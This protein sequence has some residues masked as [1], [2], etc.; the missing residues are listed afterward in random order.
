MTKYANANSVYSQK[1]TPIGKTL[2]FHQSSEEWLDVSSRID[3]FH[4]YKVNEIIEK[5]KNKKGRKPAWLKM[6]K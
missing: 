6:F 5:A 1:M 3:G 4:R 2:V